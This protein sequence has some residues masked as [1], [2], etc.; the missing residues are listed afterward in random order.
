M[1]LLSRILWTVPL[2]LAVAGCGGTGSDGSSGSD[3]LIITPDPVAA[4]TP[5]PTVTP[6]PS[7]TP[8]PVATPAPTPAPAPTPTP[9]PASS[10][11][12]TTL[13]AEEFSTAITVRPETTATKT[14][15]WNQNYWYGWP[16]NY[17]SHDDWAQNSMVSK[18][19]SGDEMH[20]QSGGV[21]KLGVAKR[22]AGG[23]DA[24]YGSRPYL[25]SIL[26]TEGS[27]EHL[28]GYFE[29]R[30]QVQNVPGQ[31][32]CFWL[33]GKENDS[34]IDIA[35]FQTTHQDEVWGSTHQRME[36]TAAGLVKLAK[37]IDKSDQL[38]PAG[39]KISDWHT[40]GFLWNE[41][42]LI[43]YVDGKQVKRVSPHPF[44]SPM[45]MILTN[46]VG[47]WS[48]ANSGATSFTG[49]DFQADY[50]RVRDKL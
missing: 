10:D 26:T 23:A 31:W 45:F 1:K 9:T 43:W 4:P 48:A 12:A 14:G 19:W 15:R 22:P 2:A 44:H 40:Y 36:L 3:G 32:P 11:G 46:G 47:G 13:F 25:G 24:K 17:S 42:E 33:W 28:Y 41:N 18:A 50:V 6:T 34:E 8:T 38:A 39:F 27:F 30:L 37:Q 20:V 5:A 16:G 7:P 21:M 35:E 29:A 49:S